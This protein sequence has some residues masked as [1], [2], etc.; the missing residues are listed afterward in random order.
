MRD[1]GSWASAP[2]PQPPRVAGEKAG[3]SLIR[4]RT[5][6]R[7]PAGTRA[8]IVFT[9]DAAP[10]PEATSPLGLPDP[11]SAGNLAVPVGEQPLSRSPRGEEG[12]GEEFGCQ[13]G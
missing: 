6:T 4:D 3:C 7:G 1:P 5:G 11:R 9:W 10:A 12:V 8:R 2:P 13:G